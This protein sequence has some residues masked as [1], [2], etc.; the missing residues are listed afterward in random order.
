[1]LHTAD[2]VLP[3]FMLY[4]PLG[5]ALQ[6]ACPALSWYFPCRQYMQVRWPVELCAVPL[7]QSRQAVMGLVLASVAAYDA[8]FASED[9][10]AAHAVHTLLPV[11]LAKLPCAHTRHTVLAWDA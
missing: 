2:E 1:M 5:H 11:T 7:T 6:I 9:F 3:V 8:G 10:P 4:V